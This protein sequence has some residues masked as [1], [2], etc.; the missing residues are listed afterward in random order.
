MALFTQELA[1]DLGTANTVI[2]KDGKVVLDEPSIISINNETGKVVDVGREALCEH[3]YG[4]MHR[5]I[6]PIRS[7]AI[8]DPESAGRML[9][10]FVRKV[11]G[12]GLIRPHLRAC[13]AIP[14]CFDE[15]AKRTI[16]DALGVAGIGEVLFIPRPV[17]EI[18]GLGFD[19]LSSHPHMTVDI[20]HDTTEIA[21]TCS[22][23]TNGSH[24]A[25]ISTGGAEM[26]SDISLY[27]ATCYG[28]H[29]NMM[30][31]AEMIKRKLGSALEDLPENEDL[32]PFEVVGPD[33]N[34]DKP[35]IKKVE[36]TYH[37]IVSCLEPTLLKIEHAIENVLSA[38][39]EYYQSIENDGVWLTG[40]GS[41]L[42]GISERFSRKFNIPFRVAD[43]PLKAVARG[44]CLALGNTDNYPLQPSKTNQPP[45]CS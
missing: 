28:F 40:G 37:E 44:T 11:T 29:S 20:G 1:I 30:V 21:I 41:L 7:G 22:G 42:R 16:H 3:Y 23:R 35:K 14:R 31:T 10:R 2:F 27:M 5:M 13:V 24:Y 15:K 34:S 45:T 17:S 39:P 36:L 19:P 9:R 8:A 43:D 4:F 26:T 18:L 6:S 12:R 38:A 32:E 33:L 25:F